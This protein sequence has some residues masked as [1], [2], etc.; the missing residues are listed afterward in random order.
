VRGSPLRPHVLFPIPYTPHVR[1]SHLNETLGYLHKHNPPSLK[2]VYR[3]DIT[4]RYCKRLDVD[5]YIFP[6]FHGLN[7]P[8]FPESMNVLR[9]WKRECSR[10]MRHGI[11]DHSDAKYAE[12]PLPPAHSM[13]L[14][15]LS[16]PIGRNDRFH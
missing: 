5:G 15:H 11:C 16:L 3:V 8:P 6:S 12:I 14:S 4:D 9:R 7:R 10:H 13:A 2:R 1:L